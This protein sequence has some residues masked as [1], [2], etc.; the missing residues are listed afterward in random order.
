VT[1]RLLLVALVALASAPPAWAHATL[2]STTPADGSV[3]ASPPRRVLVKFGDTVRVGPRNAAIRNDGR[4]VLGGGPH[5]SHGTTLVVPLKRLADGDYTVRWSIVSDDGH[6]E[7]GLI[8]FAVGAGRASPSAALTARGIV[9][10]QRALMRTLLFLGILG[11]FGIVVFVLFVLRPLRLDRA[12]ERPAAHLLFLAFLLAFLGSDALIHTV[13]AGGTRFERFMEVAATA[14]AAGGAAAALTPLYPRLRYLAWTAAGVA[15]VCPTLSGHAL[16]PDQPAVLAPL[17]DLLHLGAAGVWL[18]GLASLAFVAARA[19]GEMRVRAARRFSGLA[20]VSVVVVAATGPL[21]A[22]TE[23]S[24]VGQV[25]ST[26][27]GRAL[28]VK[29]ALLVPL[30][31]LGWLN[32]AALLGVFERLRRSVL[33]ELVLVTG[34]VIAVGVLADERP[35]RVAAAVAQP[36]RPPPATPPLPPLGTFVDARELGR[37]AVAVAVGHALETVTVIG[38]DGI[39]VSGLRVV[40]DGFR[41]HACGVGCYRAQATATPTE[42]RVGRSRLV[43]TVPL[44]LRPAAKLLARATRAFESAR[45]LQIDEE[46]RSS[47]E[48]SQVSHFWLRAPHSLRYRISGGPEAIVIGTRRWD[49]Y[50]GGKWTESPQT[51]LRV[52]EPY[53]SDRSRNAYLAGPY[54]L[55]FVDP[56]LPAWFRLTVDR[57]TGRPVRMR[58]IAAAHFMTDRYSAFDRPVPISP[59]SR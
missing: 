55:T 11:A 27:Y 31:G 37:F 5:V 49:R 30:I 59:P 51:P 52:P 4:D 6:A 7:E 20:L 50:P 58:M 36:A 23:L 54:E 43:F 38:P 18:G 28:I 53:W 16:D 46:L 17:D 21:R 39:G 35:G 1:R 9:T 40:V 15:F 24:A 47:P 42:V 56:Q 14:A 29:T 57:H 34:V 10:W 22:V 41:A 25:W 48:R 32:R 44:R 45:T 33:V 8:A 12:L 19:P 13:S 2:V 26:S 3:L